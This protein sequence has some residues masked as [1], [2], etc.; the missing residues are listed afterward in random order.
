VGVWDEV[1]QNL[2]PGPKSA[3]PEIS[4]KIYPQRFRAMSRPVRYY[5]T[6]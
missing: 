4:Y 6:F 3:D 1:V 5:Q 2:I